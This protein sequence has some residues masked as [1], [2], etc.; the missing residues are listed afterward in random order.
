[1]NILIAKNSGLNPLLGGVSRVSLTLANG[2]REQGHR[3]FFI[4]YKKFNHVEE[5]APLEEQILLPDTSCA[6]SDDNIIFFCHFIKRNSIDVLL[7]QEAVDYDFTR[8]CV[9]VRKTTSVKLVSVLHFNPGYTIDLLSV[10]CVPV[11]AMNQIISN[12]KMIVRFCLMPWLRFKRKKNCNRL[13]STVYNGSDAT[14]LLSNSFVLRFQ[15]WI[16]RKETEKLHVIPN[17]LSFPLIESIPQKKKQLLFVGRLVFSPKRPDYLLEIWKRIYNKF[18][19]WELIVIGEGEYKQTL[20]KI[21]KLNK[22][23]RVKFVGH[24]APESYYRDASILCMTSTF[25]GFGM[26]LIEA[27]QFGTIPF[28]FNSFTALSDII[29]DGVNGCT[30]IPYDLDQYA[31]RLMEVMSN[32]DERI[33]LANNAFEKAKRFRLDVICEH[34][35]Q[36]FENI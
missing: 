32:D 26:V 18:P 6:Y 3:V 9:E 36:L 21:A 13:Y 16:N 25:E 4:A 5:N 12:I 35:I 33:W 23:E 31:S 11:G 1:M 22:L 34:W 10:P 20:E 28:A 8:L 17:P 27:Q 30:I 29:F 2:F 19:D 15:F 24:V 7:N 14:V